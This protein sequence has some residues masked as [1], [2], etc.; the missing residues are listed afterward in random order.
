MKKINEYV[1]LQKSLAKSVNVEYDASHSHSHQ[2]IP[3]ARTYETLERISSGL[4]QPGSCRS[5]A[6]TGPYGS[7]KS[8]FALFFSELLGEAKSIASKKAWK[9]LKDSNAAL[10]AVLQ[11]SLKINGAE[12]NFFA[13]GMATSARESILKSFSRAVMHATQ[14]AKISHKNLKRLKAGTCTS[15]EIIQLVKDILEVRP[16][17]IVLDEFGKNLEAFRDSTELSDLYLLQQLAELG[18]SKTKYPFLLITLK[19]LAFSEYSSDL[20][21]SAR[22]ELSKVQG[23]FEEIMYVESGSETRRLI[24]ELF[25]DDKTEFHDSARKWWS[26]NL[27]VITRLGVHDLIDSKMFVRCMPLHPLTLIALPELCSRFAQNDRTLF[28]YLGSND[29]RSVSSFANE[30]FWLKGQSLPLV[31][32]SHLYDYF[33]ES[34]ATSISSSDLASRWLEIETTIR[35]RTGKSEIHLEIL[36]TIGVLNL[37]SA[38]GSLR[39]TRD[40]VAFAVTNTSFDAANQEFK[41]GISDLE[42]AGV[43]VYRDFAD[44]Y[45]IWV[46]TDYPLIERIRSARAEA[47]HIDLANLLN[48]CAPLAPIVAGRHS[49]RTGIL[50][51]FQSRF[52][53]PRSLQSHIRDSDETIDGY[54][55]CSV[56]VGVPAE[57]EVVNSAKPFVLASPSNV[58]EVRNAAIEAFALGSVSKNIELTA[59]NDR[60]ALREVSE[61]LSHVTMKLLTLI[62]RTWMSRDASW[63]LV[64]NQ[65]VSV[66]PLRSASQALSEVCDS[67]YT[68]SP[69]IKNEMIA[70]R[71]VTGQGTRAR[72]LLSEAMLINTNVERFGI[73]GFGPER[74]MYDAIFAKSGLHRRSGKGVFELASHEGAEESWKPVLAC[75]EKE[76]DIAVTSRVSISAICMKLQQPPYGLKDGLIPLLVL[77]EIIR[78]GESIL[79]YEHGSLVTEIDD[80]IA[81][82]LIKNP[83]HFA[84]KA[85]TENQRTSS[86]LKDYAHELFGDESNVVP[87]VMS[88]G[89]SLYQTIKELPRFTMTTTLHL[90]SEALLARQMIKDA[91]ELDALLLHGLPDAAGVKPISLS[92]KTNGVSIRAVSQVYKEIIGAY[93]RLLDFIRTTIALEVGFEPTARTTELRDW[94]KEPASRISVISFEPNLKALAF[95]TARTDLDDEQWIE[96]VAMVI[97]SGKIPKAWDDAQVELFKLSANKFIGSFKR[98]SALIDDRNSG[99]NQTR[100][101]TVTMSDGSEIESRISESRIT[102]KE[103]E[104]VASN[105]LNLL[106]KNGLTKSEAKSA[107]ASIILR[108]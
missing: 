3:T 68:S 9:Q 72:R 17:M 49:Q 82:R 18:Q 71:E 101:V 16:L 30:N 57:I 4:M 5:F 43:L 84:V 83:N 55:V 40:A 41:N 85:M 80:A 22:R 25:S 15:E 7:G 79:L 46:G 52:G 61:R 11:E 1:H 20:E 42:R 36:K 31:R 26:N 74:A 64:I 103:I 37:V 93:P 76:F 77:V 60:V 6:I 56:E 75:L 44:E 28:A 24:M 88:I 86:V 95:A 106:K 100:L 104:L 107:A 87:S 48:Q 108:K 62:Q 81:E 97:A 78:R 10:A 21:Q 27:E 35:D 98:V 63:Y 38:G 14:T 2:Y 13:I 70:R 45:R 92:G 39:A 12:K 59:E 58:E 50:R 96:H 73:E 66:L 32:L 69:E 23:R 8:S 54:L 51:V 29:P 94:F 65:S 90:S 47:R 67:F 33:V 19:H 105:L 91:T 89:K 102:N 99:G 34:V 53:N